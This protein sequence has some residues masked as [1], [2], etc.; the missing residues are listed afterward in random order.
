MRKAVVFLCI[1]AGLLCE[2]LCPPVLG[3]MKEGT[4][5]TQTN[6]V[7]ILHDVV[8]FAD[9]LELGLPQPI[10]SNQVT[11]F[12]GYRPKSGYGTEIVSIDL[13]GR[14]HFTV[15]VENLLVCNFT[16]RK[17]CMTVLWRAEDIKPL[18]QPSK[19]TKEQA[20]QMAHKYLERL[21]YSEKDMPVLPPKVNQR[22]WQPPGAEKAELLP[23]FAVEWPWKKYPEWQYFKMEIDGLREKV[24]YFSTIHPRQDAPQPDEN[25]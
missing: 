7:D 4:T 3:R 16:D 17:Y 10:T 12:S 23:F 9:T 15:D 19:I 5:I 25:K 14:Y 18:I 21:G 13:I 2:F 22:K 1:I 24:T 8:K 6:L 11:R 20:L